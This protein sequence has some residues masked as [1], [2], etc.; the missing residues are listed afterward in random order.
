MWVVITPALPF[1]INN[2]FLLF[3]V[4]LSWSSL[5]PPCIQLIVKY[6]PFFFNNMFLFLFCA[7]HVGSLL[8]RTNYSLLSSISTILSTL[9]SIPYTWGFYLSEVQIR[10]IIFLLLHLQEHLITSQIIGIQGS[11]WSYPCLLS[12]HYFLQLSYKDLKLYPNLVYH[13]KLSCFSD[14]VSLLIPSLLL[15]LPCLV[16]K[17]PASL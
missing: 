12:Q 3:L 15:I 9:Q 14:S 13:K 11:P 10:H 8:A 6:G 17:I 2:I 5:T 7:F 16:H 1:P 4:K